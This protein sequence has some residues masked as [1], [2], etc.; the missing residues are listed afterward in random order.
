MRQL[1][2]ESKSGPEDGP[3]H[4][5][6][7]RRL[8]IDREGVDGDG[9]VLKFIRG[10]EQDIRKK[11]SGAERRGAV[12]LLVDKLFYRVVRNAEPYANAGP[13]GPSRTP[14]QPDAWGEVPVISVSQPV[15]NAFITGVHDSPRESESARTARIAIG[16]SQLRRQRIVRSELTRIYGGDPARPKSLNAIIAIVERLAQLPAQSVI[17]SHI[18]PKLPTILAVEVD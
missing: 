15:G 18:G 17:Q 5:L 6:E 3:I 7:A 14:R 13:A 1:L 2:A 8:V 16:R 4:R 10:V 12:K 9:P 11:R